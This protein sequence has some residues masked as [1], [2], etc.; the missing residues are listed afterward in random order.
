MSITAKYNK[1]GLFFCQRTV[2]LD[3]EKSY[4]RFLKYLAPKSTILDAGCGSGRDVK[5]F[6]ERGYQ[7]HGIDGSEEIVKF[8]S[9]Y[10]GSHIVHLCFEEMTF[11]DNFDGIWA[12]ASLVHMSPKELE[13]IFPRFIKA[14]RP[15]GYWHILFKYGDD[16]CL[17]DLIPSFFQ[18]QN[19]LTA[20]LDKF[21]ELLIQEI[22][23]EESPLAKGGI[24]KWIGCIV[25]KKRSL[26]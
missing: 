11:Q 21:P 25:K 1:I 13:A 6:Y 10:T 20:L 8:A 9:E 16:P 17:D 15:D 23:I 7:V 22:W 5:A 3:M 19:S 2:D 14:L 12:N 18:N 24:A 4:L 26:N